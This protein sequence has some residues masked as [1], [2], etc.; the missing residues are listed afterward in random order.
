MVQFQQY[1]TGTRHK[2]ELLHWSGKRVQTKSQKVLGSDPTLDL[3][4]PSPM[5]WIR[6]KH[7]T[8]WNIRN[9]KSFDSYSGHLIPDSYFPI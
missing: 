8:G 1:G 4:A 2:L 6:L 3:F 9:E 5:E 7:L